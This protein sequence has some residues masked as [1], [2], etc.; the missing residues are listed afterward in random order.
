MYGSLCGD[1]VQASSCSEQ[2]ESDL[3]F[4][5]RLLCNNILLFFF[6]FKWRG[7]GPHLTCFVS[8][9]GLTIFSEELDAKL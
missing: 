6:V 4:V 5:D 9:Y 3:L 7:E 2:I 1:A 8:I